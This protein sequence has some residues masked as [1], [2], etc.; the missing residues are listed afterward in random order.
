M[1]LPLRRVSPRMAITLIAAASLVAGGLAAS[2][3]ARAEDA[4]RTPGQVVR[5]WSYVGPGAPLVGA[6]I[7]LRDRAGTVLATGVTTATGTY[8]FDLSGRAPVATPLTVTTSRG[9]AA[10]SRFDGHLKARVFAASSNYAVVQNSLISTAASQMATTRRG[11]AIAT[12]KVR[13]ALGI[14]RGSLAEALR[15]PQGAVSYSRLRREARRAGGFDVLATRLADAAPVAER[16][17]PEVPGRPDRLYQGSD[18]RRSG[19]A[20]QGRAGL[21]A[22]RQADAP[23]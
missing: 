9:T 10:G 1:D 18:W 20:G 23:G 6:T 22:V 15:L 17:Q 4:P 8:T 13:R 2:D 3:G 5:T 11:Y 14:P 21:S 16:D 7:A 12:G 19:T